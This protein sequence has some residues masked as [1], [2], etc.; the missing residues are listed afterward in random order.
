MCALCVIFRVDVC[1]LLFLCVINAIVWFVC[2]LVCVVVWCVV[3]DVSFI[4]CV[5]C[6]RAVFV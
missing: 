2:A 5:V 1:A 6:V 3:C 4:L